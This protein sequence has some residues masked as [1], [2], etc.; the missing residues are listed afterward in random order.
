MGQ[1]TALAA[2]A[3]LL[4]TGC[5]NTVT[6][7][8]SGFQQWPSDTKGA[9]YTI[10]SSSTNPQAVALSD[11]ERQTY[12]GYLAQQLQKQG[13]VPAAKPASARMVADMQVLAQRQNVEVRQPVY[14]P[15]PWWGYRPWSS[16]W[17]A[18]YYC[19][20]P[21]W[22]MAASCLTERVTV[23]AIDV[24]RLNVRIQDR[25]Q[26]K[27]GAVTPVF[28]AA[29]EYAGTASLPTAMPYL[30]ETAFDKFPGSADGKPRQVHFNADTGVKKADK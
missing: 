30:M 11:L 14:V 23:Q 20:S 22:G 5:A 13:L 3:A 19:D 25:A 17:D 8:V 7:T 18:S 9:T 2:I 24:Y 4:V 29:A 6:T 15:A 12:E 1:R 26:N 28:E 10:T 27:E 21:R 16:A